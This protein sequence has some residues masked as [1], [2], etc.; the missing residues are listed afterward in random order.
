MIR[1]EKHNQIINKK[2]H[3]FNSSELGA[4]KNSILYRVGGS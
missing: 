4:D 3:N 1:E 2:S